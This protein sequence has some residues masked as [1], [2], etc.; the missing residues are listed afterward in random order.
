MNQS[1]ET[2]ERNLSFEILVLLLKSVKINDLM[3]FQLHEITMSKLKIKK[4][5]RILGI[6]RTLQKHTGR[7][8]FWSKIKQEI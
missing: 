6:K 5:C 4:L 1:L 3:N 8:D 7:I 2:H